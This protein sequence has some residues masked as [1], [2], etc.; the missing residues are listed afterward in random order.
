MATVSTRKISP[1]DHGRKM[2][3]D[4]F[5][6]AEETEGYRYELARGVLEVTRVPNDPHGLIVSWFYIALG[7]YVQTHPGL[8]YRIG[9]AGEFQLLL[10]TMLS[11]R[12]PDVAV[13]LKGRSR[14]ARESRYPAL[15]VEV[16][17]PGREAHKRDYVT[18]REEYLAYG[19]D[20]YWIVDTIKKQVM[21]LVR[22][23]DAWIEQIYKG[24]QPAQGLVLPGFSVRPNDLWKAAAEKP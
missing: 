4:E 14:N 7:Q 8:I 13:V 6:D 22:D 15:V 12:N 2:T 20:E 21:V 23:G 17:S 3:L 16:V 11:G 24:N 10:P 19:I 5:L 1:A 9:G 18:K